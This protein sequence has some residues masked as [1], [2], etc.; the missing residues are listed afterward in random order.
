MTE[1]PTSMT[2]EE[3]FAQVSTQALTA[4]DPMSRMLRMAYDAVE[5]D[6][7]TLAI[8]SVHGALLGW[9]TI[10]MEPAKL[11]TR[12]KDLLLNIRDLLARVQGSVRSDALKVDIP[13]YIEEIHAITR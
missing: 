10:S 6:D 3:R 7:K 9:A 2:K 11:D 12:T 4:D 1:T 13:R 8:M 5:A